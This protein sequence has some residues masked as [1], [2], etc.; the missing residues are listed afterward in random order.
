MP[1]AARVSSTALP[2]ATSLNSVLTAFPSSSLPSQRPAELCSFWN[3]EVAGLAAE[4]AATQKATIKSCPSACF[5]TCD[6][7]LPTFQNLIVNAHGRN[8]KTAGRSVHCIAEDTCRRLL[9]DN[10]TAGHGPGSGVV[11][12]PG[13]SCAID[14][15]TGERSHEANKCSPVLLASLLT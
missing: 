4:T 11:G 6:I 3:P 5:K 8:L 12:G 14:G 2:P 10:V 1:E 9:P 15:G 7:H 13:A